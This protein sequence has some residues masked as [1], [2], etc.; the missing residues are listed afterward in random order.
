MSVSPVSL[1]VKK[2]LEK[3]DDGAAS[4]PLSLVVVVILLLPEQRPIYRLIV[5]IWLAERLG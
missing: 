1:R 3:H 4:S 2:L 5:A